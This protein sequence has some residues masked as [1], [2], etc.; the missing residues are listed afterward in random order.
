WRTSRYLSAS[1]PTASRRIP[2]SVAG[3]REG[4]IDRI[5]LAW[6]G[7]ARRFPLLGVSGAPLHPLKRTRQLFPPVQVGGATPPE[8]VVREV[9][10]ALARHQFG[11]ETPRQRVHLRPDCR[12][13]SCDVRS[14]QP[15]SADDAVRRQLL[16]AV[17]R[18]RRAEER[19]VAELE[20]QP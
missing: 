20:H 6:R 12:R 15:Q 3:G 8:Q 10:R 5:A 14:L 19:A 1:L 18:G 9:P 4:R 11:G 16:R 17:G 2:P 13:W 7:G